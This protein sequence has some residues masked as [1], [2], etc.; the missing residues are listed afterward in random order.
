MIWG[1]GPRS[2][3]NDMEKC[4]R[5]TVVLDEWQMDFL[6]KLA[7]YDKLSVHTEVQSLLDL[8]IRETQAVMQ[9]LWDNEKG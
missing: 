4:K 1:Y 7:K 3:R 8:Q 5:Y 9:E 6:K 2:E